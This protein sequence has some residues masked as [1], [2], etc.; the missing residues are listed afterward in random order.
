MKGIGWAA[1]IGAVFLA[2]GL[3][4]YLNRL[5]D[6]WVGITLYVINI[7]AFL[8]IG[9]GDYFQTRKWNR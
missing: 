7:V 1:L 8:I 4:R 9:L 3:V 6:D 5:P 2:I